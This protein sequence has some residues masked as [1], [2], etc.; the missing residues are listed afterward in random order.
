MKREHVR[1]LVSVRIKTVFIVVLPLVTVPAT[2]QSH[3]QFIKP[4]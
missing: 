4:K 2:T 1:I 3:A